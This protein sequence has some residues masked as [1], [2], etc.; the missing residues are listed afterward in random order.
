MST[1]KVATMRPSTRAKYVAIQQRFRHLYEV[2]RRR[3]DDVHDILCREYFLSL[4]R[5][6][7]ILGTNIPETT[8]APD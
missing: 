7:I 4:S 6:Y 3:L 5:I 8:E 2:E 1:L